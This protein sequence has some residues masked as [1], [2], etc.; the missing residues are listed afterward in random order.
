MS[1]SPP[2]W[3]ESGQSAGDRHTVTTVTTKQRTHHVNSSPHSHT[4]SHLS[5]SIEVLM[6][7]VVWIHNWVLDIGGFWDQILCFSQYFYQS[8]SNILGIEIKFTLENIQGTSFTWLISP[9]L[10]RDGLRSEDGLGQGVLSQAAGWSVQCPPRGELVAPTAW[11][12]SLDLIISI[13]NLISLVWLS[14]PPHFNEDSPNCLK[15]LSWRG[16]M[17]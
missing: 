4:I 14:F 17:M 9:P 6:W 8:I 15:Y 13:G 3:A 12:L 10:E 1:S 2:L 16:V 11:C 5:I 7:Q